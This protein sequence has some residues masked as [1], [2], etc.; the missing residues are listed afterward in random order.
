[1]CYVYAILV[2]SSSHAISS[3]AEIFWL[4]RYA[5]LMFNTFVGFQG[6]YWK[7]VIYIYIYIYIIYSLWKRIHSLTYSLIEESTV[8]HEKKTNSC[9]TSKNIYHILRNTRV[10]YRFHKSCQL[11]L[12]WS[13]PI[14]SS[15]PSCTI[16]IQL[17][18]RCRF[19]VQVRISL[20]YL[21]K[22]T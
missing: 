12:S 14:V 5:L 19:V 6:F 16:T 20:K 1:L 18:R 7:A 13:K 8:V 9:L 4:I 11:S 15:L 22:I 21:R 3:V 2:D 17:G 10:H